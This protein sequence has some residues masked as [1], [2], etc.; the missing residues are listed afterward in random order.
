MAETVYEGTRPGTPAGTRPITPAGTRPI[1]PAGTRT[2]RFMEETI[3]SEYLQP[4]FSAD[5]KFS[6]NDI[7]RFRTLVYSYYGDFGRAFPWR[8]TSDPYR[9]LLSEMMLQQTQTERVLPKYHQFLEAYPDFH[10]LAEASA[11]D[12]LMLWKG[13]GYNRRALAL[14]RIAREA[15][16]RWGAVLPD[17]EK[18]LRSLYMVGPATA[19]AVLSFAY[20][21]PALY[22]ETNIRR[23][24]LYCFFHDAEHVKDAELYAA[25]DR[26]LDRTDPKNWYYALMDYGVF[27]KK[28]IENPN[29]RSAHYAKQP[30]F[31]NSDR[32]I[33]GKLLSLFIEKGASAFE[34]IQRYL[35]FPE[36]RL[37]KCLDALVKEGFLSVQEEAGQTQSGSTCTS[38]ES[39]KSGRYSDCGDDAVNSPEA[40]AE[41]ILIYR[42]AR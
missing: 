37:K 22:L 1:T 21:K 8:E 5:G 34:E 42:L 20:R 36:E 3:R 26:V 35:D 6:E 33:R 9:I 27:L 11:S 32:E 16:D 15:V 31:K 38:P 30:V 24:L 23:V 28:M 7:V 40:A 29:R 39:C 13:L 10:A 18:Q 41:Q 25:L 19:A 2:E 4:P 17:D 14:L 12:I